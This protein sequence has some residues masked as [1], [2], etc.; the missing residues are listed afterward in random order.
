MIPYNTLWF[1]LKTS[2]LSLPSLLLSFPPPSLSPLPPLS[3]LDSP[4]TAAAQPPSSD[5]SV[6]WLSTRRRQPSV[7]PAVGV[8]G[9]GSL[10][11][12]RAM[13]GAGAA[14]T[15]AGLLA[16]LLLLL[17]VVTGQSG[18]RRSGEDARHHA[19]Q[20]GWS[21]DTHRRLRESRVWHIEH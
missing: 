9:G 12:R 18:L 15:S 19:H 16:P 21:G 2:F 4:V 11:G 1:N 3:F 13:A 17:S 6:A 5:G 8:D 14:V 7:S 10:R 20:R